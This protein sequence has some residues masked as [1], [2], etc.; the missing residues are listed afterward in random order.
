MIYPYVEPPFRYSLIFEFKSL[1]GRL[2][3]KRRSK[4]KPKENLL[5]NICSGGIF[6]EGWTH[7]DFFT[8]RWRIWKMLSYSYADVETDL[9]FPLMGADN[10]ADGVYSGHTLEHLYPNHAQQFLKEIHRIL[11]PSHWLRI[12]VPDLKYF[13]DFYNGKI[14]VDRWKYKAEGIGS[15]TQN[16]GHHSVWDEEL[17]TAALEAV[18]FINIRKV[19]FGSEGSDSRLIIEEESRRTGTLVMQAQKKGEYY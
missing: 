13:I 11:K 17:L 5:L 3:L 8:L 16:W 10:I 4:I 2:F 7:V 19:D 1:I 15:L 6:K 14:N 12:N 9:R 18:G